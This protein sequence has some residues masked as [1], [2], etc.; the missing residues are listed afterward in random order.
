MATIPRP[1][2]WPPAHDLESP[3]LLAPTRIPPS[4]RGGPRPPRPAQPSGRPLWTVQKATDRQVAPDNGQSSERAAS[5]AG[6]GAGAGAAGR[7]G[8]DDEPDPPGAHFTAQRRP[9]T[10]HWGPGDTG[11]TGDT[12]DRGPRTA[13][14]EAFLRFHGRLT[15]A[16]RPQPSRVRR[17]FRTL[18]LRISFGRSRCRFPL[19]AAATK[20]HSPVGKNKNSVVKIPHAAERL[21]P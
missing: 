5:G 21:G 6:A 8:H 2:P 18:E 15:A 1:P 14:P 16:G 7:R 20:E 4:L 17:G 13:D 11:D 19:A 9:R 12:G 3:A 10:G